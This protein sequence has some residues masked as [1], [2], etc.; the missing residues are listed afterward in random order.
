MI[1]VFLLFFVE[2]LAFRWGNA[3]L[4]KAGVTQGYGKTRN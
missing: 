4:A 2:L 1:A 3:K